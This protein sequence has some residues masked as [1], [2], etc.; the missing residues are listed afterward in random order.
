MTGIDIGGRQLLLC[1]DHVG[2]CD[3]KH[4]FGG[5]GSAADECGD[6]VHQRVLPPEGQQHE[7]PSGLREEQGEGLVCSAFP[8]TTASRA[9]CQQNITCPVYSAWR[10]RRLL[11]GP[12][13][14]LLAPSCFVPCSLVE[15][16]LQHGS[17][18]RNQT[19]PYSSWGS[20]FDC[21]RGICGSSLALSEARDVMSGEKG[22]PGHFS[23]RTFFGITLDY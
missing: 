15:R 4:V 13:S 18:G 14:R 19:T 10:R 2:H 22:K 7:P 11:Y 17:R 16:R 12:S 5:T 20:I 9:Y 1:D 21:R 8:Q 6:T 23:W 3:R